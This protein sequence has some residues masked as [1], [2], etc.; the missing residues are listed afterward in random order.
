MI[1][2]V[3]VRFEAPEKAICNVVHQSGSWFWFYFF[4]WFIFERQVVVSFVSPKEVHSLSR[5]FVLNW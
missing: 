4:F 1:A 3:P 2:V 5:F